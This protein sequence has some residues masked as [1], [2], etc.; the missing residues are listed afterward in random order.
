MRT[1]IR[2][3][4][5]EW[6]AAR[7]E[8]I[9]STDVACILGLSPYRSEGDVAREKASGEEPERDPRTARRLRL[10]SA[11]E[12]LIRVEDE[13]EH[14]IK[15]RRLN[16]LYVHDSHPWAATS[17]DFERVG[18]RCIV[19]TK[20][21][22]DRRWDAGLPPDV[23]VQ[24]R[25]QMGVAGYPAAHVAALRYG[26]DLECYDVTHDQRIFDG[27]LRI[28]A[29][30]RRRMREGG[31]F[32]ESKD[33]IN[34]AYPTDNGMEMVADE[35]M[36]RWGLLYLDAKDRKEAADA[37]LDASA[38]HL[39]E[40]L[41]PFSAVRGSGW[42][43]TWKRSKDRTI[44]EHE[45][46]AQAYRV[47]IEEEADPHMIAQADFAKSINTHTEPGRR[48]LLVRREA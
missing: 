29:D 22:R 8:L 14:G 47:L 24:V 20:S 44:V 4:T 2:L 39:K 15:I 42:R 23:E 30:F 32:S 35:E 5:D 26:S 19:E 31:P 38:L 36:D 27:M 48:P 3:G 45:L 46:V 1:D 43:A 28:A 17:M 33:S 34:R 7:R 10:G 37:D 12:D 16:Y 13:H 9:T 21:S 40:R 41:G 25:W 18:E 11:L 6:K